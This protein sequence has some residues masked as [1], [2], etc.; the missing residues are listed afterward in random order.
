VGDDAFADSTPLS[1]TSGPEDLKN[2]GRSELFYDGKSVKRPEKVEFHFETSSGSYGA[3]H[4]T[5]ACTFA[6]PGSVKASGEVAIEV[7]CGCVVTVV[8]RSQRGRWHADFMITVGA[9]A[10]VFV[11]RG[12]MRT[13]LFAGHIGAPYVSMLTSW[14]PDLK[15][16]GWPVQLLGEWGVDSAKGPNELGE[17]ADGTYGTL[18]FGRGKRGESIFAWALEPAWKANGEWIEDRTGHSFVATLKNRLGMP[19]GRF[20]VAE[21]A[22][23]A[24]M[25][26]KPV[27]FFTFGDILPVDA[28]SPYAD[29]V[30]PVLRRGPAGRSR[31]GGSNRSPYRDERDKEL[32]RAL[33]GA[34]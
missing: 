20:K 32:I 14:L 33:Q 9:G 26:P 5:K 21:T 18:I 3:A 15:R 23:A 25:S 10:R 13:G 6:E 29:A 7:V 34:L 31:G 8:A 30:G 22:K 11:G 4:T 24:W 16:V 27:E 2:D 19:P 28:D 12:I 17:L 1:L